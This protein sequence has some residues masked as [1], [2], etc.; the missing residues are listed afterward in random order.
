MSRPEKCCDPEAVFELADGALGPSG[1]R[2]MLSHLEGCPGCKKSYEHE[3]KLTRGLGGTGAPEPAFRS[4]C[5]EVAISLP[6][7]TAKARLSWAALAA[8]ILL[9]TV[10]AM[11]LEGTSPVVPATGTLDMF[12]GFASLFADL[13]ATMLAFAAPVIV[14]ALAAGAIFDAVIAGVVYSAIRRR[15]GQTRRA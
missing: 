9:V 3:K 2:E 13:S 12:L 4:V 10:V 5:R 7:R 15:T 6:T 8:F 11:S 1:R 14:I